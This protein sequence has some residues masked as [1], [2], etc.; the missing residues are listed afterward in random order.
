[1]ETPK[2]FS[3]VI[4]ERGIQIWVQR[5]CPVDFL[6]RVKLPVSLIFTLKCIRFRDWCVGALAGFARANATEVM[7]RAGETLSSYSCQKLGNF[8]CTSTMGPRLRRQR[9]TPIVTTVYRPLAR[10]A[11]TSRTKRLSQF[12]LAQRSLPRQCGFM[13]Q[14]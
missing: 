11:Y 9:A 4:T 2:V 7:F 8:R 13:W 14:N 5:F 6:K 12:F 1:M 10:V 3:C